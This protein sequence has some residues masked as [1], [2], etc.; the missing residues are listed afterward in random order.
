M[1]NLLRVSFLR[2]KNSMLTAI[3]LIGILCCAFINCVTA[4]HEV[5]IG[6]VSFNDT[7]YPF[8][9]TAAMLMTCAAVLLNC[10]E[11]DPLRNA[12]IAGYS[13]PAIL[14]AEL[15]PA[16][17]FACIA[18]LLMLL[19]MLRGT[20][21]LSCF[22][23]SGLLLGAL[24]ILMMFCTAA[25]LTAVV[26][27]NSRTRTFAI[28]LCA[29]CLLGGCAGAKPVFAS[30]MEGKD[31]PNGRIVQ[32]EAGKQKFIVLSRQPNPDYI[33]PP[34]RGKIEAI[35]LILPQTALHLTETHLLTDRIPEN[36]FLEPERELTVFRRMQC[37]SMLHL[38]PAVQLGMMLLITVLGIMAIRHRDMN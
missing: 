31:Y 19:P 28:I 17:L 36:P 21:V 15:I 20:Q 3:C 35:S 5:V 33:A 14:L 16:V 26:S 8:L 24:S 2:W 10:C 37:E 1:R 25:V 32:N 18:A 29:A 23:A 30:L 9:M 22:P 27:L 38:F 4:Y 13:K 7:F 11:A 34:L 12:V 6:T